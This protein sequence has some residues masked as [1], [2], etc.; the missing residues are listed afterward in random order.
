MKTSKLVIMALFVLFVHLPIKKKYI[1]YCKDEKANLDTSSYQK[2]K[3]VKE[4]EKSDGSKMFLEFKPR[5]FHGQFQWFLRDL[6]NGFQWFWGK[7]SPI[8]VFCTL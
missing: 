2:V 8:N 3:I 1:V 4:V 7:P 5:F 6:C